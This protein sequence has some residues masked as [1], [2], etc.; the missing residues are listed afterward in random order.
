V[1]FQFNAEQKLG[2]AENRKT[3][4]EEDWAYSLSW[5]FLKSL[6]RSSVASEGQA[7]SNGLGRRPKILQTTGACGTYPLNGHKWTQLISTNQIS[8]MLWRLEF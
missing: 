3:T 6:Y 5:A 1:L 4:R 7:Q 2:W 8:G